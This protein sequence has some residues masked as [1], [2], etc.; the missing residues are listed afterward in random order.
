VA[1]GRILLVAEDEGSREAIVALLEARTDL[2]VRSGPIR[3]RFAFGGPGYLMS[4]PDQAILRFLLAQN[5]E[6]PAGSMSMVSVNR[7]GQGVTAYVD[8]T[9]EGYSYLASRRFQ[10]RT[11]TTPVT[12]RPANGSSRRSS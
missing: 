7:G 2:T 9:E 4:L 11:M 8:V 12:L 3:R 10:L 6:M 1:A 5:P